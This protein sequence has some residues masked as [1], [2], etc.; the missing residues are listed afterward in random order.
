VKHFSVVT[1]PFEGTAFLFKVHGVPTVAIG[2]ILEL[3]GW[4]YRER[5]EF[6]PRLVWTRNLYRPELAIEAFRL[7][8]GQYPEATLTMCGKG[9]RADRLREYK[10]LPGLALVGFVPRSLLGEILDQNDIYINTMA[11][12]SF[13]YSVFEAMAMGLAV[14]SVPSQALENLAGPEVIAFSDDDSPGSLARATADLLADQE[15]MRRRVARGRR[16]VKQF[17]WSKL[18]PAWQSVY[19]EV[20]G[21]SAPVRR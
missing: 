7:L 4:P 5:I 8:S 3:K 17:T 9:A 15:E 10:D 11:N 18:Y 14:V 20:M 2:N 13:G 12:D 21:R 16:V 19:D 6:G 1:T